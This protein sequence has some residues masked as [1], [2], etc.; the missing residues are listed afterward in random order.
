[1]KQEPIN[2][3]IKKADQGELIKHEA[4]KYLRYWVWFAIGVFLCLLVAFLY[5]RYTPKVF[6]S[7]AKIQILNKAK[8]IEL[9]SSAFVFNRSS[10]NLENEIEILRSY[11]IIEQVVR[12]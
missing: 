10:I 2:N 4:K 12:N 3:A 6:K 9:P 8:G 1:M 5:L 11:R 7:A